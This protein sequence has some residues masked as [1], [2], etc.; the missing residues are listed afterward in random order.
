MGEG[1]LPHFIFSVHRSGQIENESITD[2]AVLYIVYD[3]QQLDIQSRAKQ[4]IIPLWRETRQTH[5]SY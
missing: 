1:T 3:F 5:T 4:S 2:I